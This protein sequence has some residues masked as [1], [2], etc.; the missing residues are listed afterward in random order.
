VLRIGTTGDYA[1]FSLE[2]RGELGGADVEAME[3]FAKSLGVEARFVRTSWSSLMQDH[4][5][6]RFD[7]AMG[8]ISVT[9]ERAA[10]AR[11]SVPYQ[12][13][14]KTPIV[15]CGTQAQFD[16]IAEI[17]RPTTRVL[18]NPGGTNEQFARARLAH[19]EII[20][21][22]D[23]RTIFDELSAGRGDVMVTDDVE[24][25]L[26]TRRERRLCRATPAT[27]THSDKAILLPRDESFVGAVDRWL[28]KEIASGAAAGRLEQALNR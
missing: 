6:G 28:Q 24:V 8:G 5:Q 16:T 11:F 12:S 25:E 17:D 21:H 10:Q 14:G 4:Q 27:F 19:A 2:A 26:Q 20:V 18:V 15:R 1:P 22:P 9:P 23:N 13:G 3:A 7:L